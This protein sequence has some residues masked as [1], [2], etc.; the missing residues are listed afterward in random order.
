MIHIS[1]EV[2]DH[3]RKH[4]VVSEEVEEA[5]MNRDGPILLE[6]RSENMR[7]TVPRYWFIALTDSGRALKLVYEWTKGRPPTL[8]TAYDPNDKEKEIYEKDSN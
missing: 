8:V 3:I 6:R 4:R 1:T 7:G 5:W 2:L